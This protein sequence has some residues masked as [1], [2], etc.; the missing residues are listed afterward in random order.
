MEHCWVNLLEVRNVIERL[1]KENII[2]DYA[3]MVLQTEMDSLKYVT[4]GRILDKE[5][6]RHGE[7]LGDVSRT[8]CS[9]C[10][11]NA[12]KNNAVLYVKSD[13][14]PNCGARMAESEEQTE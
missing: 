7:W 9:S 3:R 4:S 14:C 2:D 12:L 6:V 1:F 13:F 10:G 5:T 8:Y 11:H